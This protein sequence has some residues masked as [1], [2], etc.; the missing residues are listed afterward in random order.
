ME[1]ATSAAAT[2]GRFDEHSYLDSG[3]PVRVFMTEPT[4]LD[5][6]NIS[7]IGTSIPAVGGPAQN[8][9]NHKHTNS[10]SSSGELAQLQ[11]QM[12]LEMAG[13]TSSIQQQQLLLLQTGV[14]GVM[15]GTNNLENIQ[16]SEHQEDRGSSL[17]GSVV[18]LLGVPNSAADG[19][20]TTP[21]F[22]SLQGLVSPGTEE[23]QGCCAA[24][25]MLRDLQ[26]PDSAAAAEVKELVPKAYAPGNRGGFRVG[27]AAVTAAA[28]A[29]AGG[30]LGHSGSSAGMPG[31]GGAA[32]AVGRLAGL[33]AAGEVQAG[34][35][36]TAAAAEALQEGLG[37]EEQQLQL[38]LR[39]GKRQRKPQRWGEQLLMLDQLVDDVVGESHSSGGVNDWEQQRHVTWQQPP[40]QEGDVGMA[41]PAQEA[42]EPEDDAGDAS[43][44]AAADGDAEMLDYE[45]E[46]AIEEEGVSHHGR[47][48]SS[49][50]GTRQAAGADSSSGDYYPAAGGGSTAKSGRRRKRGSSGGG[51]ARL[52]KARKIKKGAKP[53]Y[54]NDGAVNDSAAREYATASSYLGVSKKRTGKWQAAVR[55]GHDGA[56]A[57]WCC[58]TCPKTAARARDAAALALRGPGSARLNFPEDSYSDDEL[59]AAAA[60]ILA[61]HPHLHSHL[62][63]PLVADLSLTQAAAVTEGVSEPPSI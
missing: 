9:P 50:R 11:K 54:D 1:A 34:V 24:L 12:M 62:G 41:D 44:D 33:V 16:A 26:H 19:E 5:V 23:L 39:R 51:G 13:G 37:E 43:Y 10:S 63:H 31:G 7:S 32:A 59:L 56:Y 35:A 17:N 14:A 49:L 47:R 6:L 60:Q 58:Y 29:R 3:F 42:E 52:P 28:A 22:R 40:L 46:M 25:M 30:Y 4:Y 18:Q 2:A 27:A 61:K 53:L 48:S 8:R 20:V 36:G 38:G 57:F 15:A 21:G 45:Q 55:F